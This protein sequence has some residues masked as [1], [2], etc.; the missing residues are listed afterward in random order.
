MKRL[1]LVDG[2][3]IAN[4]AFYALPLLTNGQGLYTNSVYG[5]TQ[6]LL[7]IQKDIKPDY[8]LVAFD[9]GKSTFRHSIY[10][11]YKGKRLKTPNELSGQFPMIKELLNTFGISHFELDGYEA[12]DI[13]GT[14]AQIADEKQIETIIYTGDKDMLQLAT[15]KTSIYFTRKGITE[16]DVYSP[17]EIRDKYNL[18]PGQIIDLK[19]LMGDSSDNIPGVPGVGEKTALKLLNQFGSVEAVL[20]NIKEVVGDKLKERLSENK[21]QALMSKRL[22]TICKSV[23]MELDIENYNV[24]EISNKRIY[25]LFQKMEF[26]S[27]IERLGINQ[28]NTNREYIKDNNS[29][30]ELIIEDYSESDLSIWQ[31]KFIDKV[32]LAIHVETNY[33]KIHDSEVLGI[34]LSDGLKQLYIAIE[35]A[36]RWNEFK[37]WLRSEDSPKLVYDSKRAELAL[38]K[39]HI[40]IKGVVS[41]LY[42]SNYLINPSDGDNDLYEIAERNGYKELQKDENVYGK[43][44][45]RKIP[46][47][48]TLTKHIGTKA[49]A[50]FTLTPMLEKILQENELIELLYKIELPLVEVLADMEKNGVLIDVE[51]LKL[52]GEEIN[53]KLEDLKNSIYKIAGTE[54][55]I[56]S[57]KQL[58]VILFDKLQLPVIKKNKTGYSTDVDVLEK[59]ESSH[60]II[61]EIL[62]YRTLGKLQST[63]IEGLLKIIDP[64]THKIHT[65]YNQAVTAT[66]RLSST[67]PNLQNIPIRL[68]EGRKIRKVFIPTEPNW[69]ILSADY[70]QIELRVLAHISNDKNLIQAFIDDLDIHT[71]TAMDIFSVKKEEVT[72]DMRRQAKAVNFGIVYGI[73]DYGLSQN[74]KISRKEAAEFIKKYFLVFSGVDGYMREIVAEAKIKGYVSTLLNRRRYLPD[75]NSS[76]FNIRSFAERTAMNTPIQG[77]AADIIKIAMVKIYQLMKEQK[78]QSILKL[79]VHDELIFEIHPEETYIMTKLVKETMENALVLKIPLKVDISLGKTWY[80]AK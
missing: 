74:L 58:G 61:G 45:K 23:P 80:E 14:V 65:S 53:S 56:N 34:S 50:I 13:I 77:T 55:N 54:F 41:D 44:A 62:H 78:L 1:V 4:R 22:A 24:K 21:E 40:D 9:A 79:Q 47:N 8:I 75:I 71:R 64:V 25:E 15:D 28:E 60:C 57:P 2:N 52:M 39:N 59:L 5:F 43:G 11:E 72:S 32:K 6:I 66:G 19:G 69:L 33:E 70:S 18:S 35:Q 12:D 10:K 26:T 36:S 51:S 20:A 29:S 38:Y 30:T 73:S 68:E 37:A 63:Y 48:Q 17:K 16:V 67:E 31:G 7:K 49:N 46:D 3:S 42:L 76:N 27:L